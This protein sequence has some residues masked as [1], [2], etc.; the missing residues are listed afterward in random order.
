[1]DKT[2]LGLLVRIVVDSINSVLDSTCAGVENCVVNSVVALVAKILPTVVVW[3]ETRSTVS[4]TRGVSEDK[5][6]VKVDT[7]ESISGVDSIER[8]LCDSE[9]RFAGATR[10]DMKFANVVPT[11]NELPGY[12]VEVTVT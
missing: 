3:E 10:F 5:F 8:K 12:I 9:V 4:V 11:A 2:V 1:M 7:S 6:C